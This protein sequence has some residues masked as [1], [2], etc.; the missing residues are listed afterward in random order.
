MT[1]FAFRH[2]TLVP[3]ILA[4]FMAIPALAAD[5][6]LLLCEA[7]LTPTA[8]EF[9][10][11]V[12]PTSS[13]ISLERYY[14]SDD[15]DY[16]L[17]PGAFGATGGPSISST[18]FIVQF[19]AG[20][21]IAPYAVIVVAFDGAGFLQHHGF[22]ADYEIHG[23]DSGTPDMIAVDV[24][25]PT[26]GLTNGGESAVLFFWDG[27]SDLVSDVDMVNLGTPTDANDIGDKTGVAVDGPDAGSDPAVYLPDGHT[28]PQQASD[29]GSEKSTKR[30]AL[31][32][33]E[34]AGGG[35][36]I[37]GNDETME[38]IS[39]TWDGPFIAPDPGWCCITP[40]TCFAAVDLSDV[41]TTRLTIHDAI[42]DHVR[43]PYSS[44]Q[45]WVILELADEDPADDTRILD[46][47]QNASY[48][49]V[50]DRGSLYEREHTWP[51]SYGF[52]TDSGT[53]TYPRSDYH[54]LFL[55]DEAYN[56]L[57]SNLPFDSC[58]TMCDEHPTVDNNGQGGNGGGYPGDSNWRRGSG[59]TGTWEV[60]AGTLGGRRGDVARALF[61]MD[62]RYDGTDHRDETPEP[63]LILTDDRGL[64]SS[65]SVPQD[66]AY[67]GMLSVL[68]EWHT[69]DPPD[70]VETWRNEAVFGYQ[71]NRNP[72]IDHPEWVRCVYLEDCGLI[73]TDGFESGDTM[74]WSS[75]VP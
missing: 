3:M 21:G 69:Q 24:G 10:E 9:I 51:Q 59:T 40:E 47:Y 62:V 48:E 31:E 44:D 17:L 20:A 42:D 32:I 56:G 1:T 65:D 39:L 7:A 35:N 50:T 4:A 64:L 43:T 61:Y 13:S 14:L 28:M 75:A 25:S 27:A 60:W 68:L 74:A 54:A 70:A 67:M 41:A 34:S 38:D 46:I 23:T 30:I 66:P 55:A 18:D 52:P 33:G 15:E 57:R 73:F 19:P 37:T 49:K 8:E 71:R 22:P 6:H 12:N 11:I 58:D 29:P 45:S 2:P 72:F 16:A 53:S 36:G 63:D 26:A 5:D